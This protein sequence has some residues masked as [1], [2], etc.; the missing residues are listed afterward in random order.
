MK[1]I[2]TDLYKKVAGF[3]QT[4]EKEDNAKDVA[5]NR[6]KLVLMQDRTNLTP[7]LLEKMRGEM[8]AVLARY[9]EMDQEA[10][11]LNFEQEGDQMALMLSIPVLRAKDDE[12]I[13]AILDAEAAAKAK[14][15]AEEETEVEEVEI[16][17]ETEEEVEETDEDVS[18]DETEEVC[19]A[20]DVI[21]IVEISES[22]DEVEEL[23]EADC[24]QRL[25]GS[26]ASETATPF[27]ASN[28]EETST[29]KSKKK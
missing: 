13:Q 23:E 12:E 7:F 9:V 14:A 17:E 27:S 4:Q 25:E 20:E 5:V 18:E 15:E 11:E 8:I 16:E 2:F 10:L 28:Q 19:T 22:P 24:E 29:K 1:D 6:M 21:E 26:E 3:F